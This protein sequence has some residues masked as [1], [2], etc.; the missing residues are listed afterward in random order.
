VSLVEPIVVRLSAA[1]IFSAAS[2]GL[3]RQVSAIQSGSKDRGGAV[4]DPWQC[5]IEGAMAELALCKALG[6]HWI[7][8]INAHSQP[9]VGRLEVR[10]RPVDSWDLILRR[11]DRPE[12]SYVLLCGANGVYRLVG[13]IKGSDGQRALYLRDPTGGEREPAFFVPQTMLTPITPE[14]LEVW[15]SEWSA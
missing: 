10:V 4:R 3:M 8:S 11:K 6:V 12:A 7:A 5:H 2:I 13:W 1:E 9:D 15:R 14:T